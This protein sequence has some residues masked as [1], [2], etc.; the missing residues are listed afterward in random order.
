M[1]NESG[2]GWLFLS[3]KIKLLYNRRTVLRGEQLIQKR[4]AR[5]DV[6]F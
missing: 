3:N 2:T 1:N 5:R 4:L 6:A